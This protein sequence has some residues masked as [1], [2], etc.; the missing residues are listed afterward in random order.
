MLLHASNILRPHLHPSREENPSALGTAAIV[1]L[2]GAAGYGVYRIATDGKDGGGAGVGLK[3]NCGDKYKHLVITASGYTPENPGG[4][5]PFVDADV[6]PEWYELATK[7]STEAHARF[8]ALGAVECEKTGGINCGTATASGGSYSKWNSL[9]EL[10]NRIA[11]RYDGLSDP[12]WTL[13]REK[14]RN[15]AQT[16][17]AD[18]IC[19]MDAADDAIASYE[20]IIPVT[21]GALGSARS[22]VPWWVWA[23]GATGAAAGGVALGQYYIRN[24]RERS[25]PG[26]LRRATPR[27]AQGAT[28]DDFGA[29]IAESAMASNRGAR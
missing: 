17:I 10:N 7:L 20:G 4:S 1:L 26:A 28:G 15:E 8:L 23:M 29:R 9:L 3:K 25:A 18:S 13:D 24:R 22:P 19:M 11:A 5:V 12:T 27:P 2:V 6:Y 21:P 14:A 16:V